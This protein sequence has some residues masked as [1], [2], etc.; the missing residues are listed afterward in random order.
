MEK[1]KTG[2]L[3]LT[4]INRT[5]IPED[6][7]CPV[8]LVKADTLPQGWERSV[9]VCWEKGI[10]IKT[11]YDRP[12]DPPS[13]DCTMIIEVNNPFKEPRIHR[14]MPAGLED[15]ET[16]RQEVLYGIHDDWI[17]PEEGKWEYTYH[18]RIFNYTL[19][20]ESE[21]V[22]QIDFVVEKLA[23]TPFS[24]RAQAVTWKCWMDP[25]FDDPPCLQRLW[26]RIIDNHL[27]LNVHLRSNDAF[28]AA[29]MNMFAFTELQ[30]L[31]AEKIS[32]KTNKKIKPGKYIHIADS[33]HI[34][35]SYFKEFKN[36]LETVKKRSFEERTWTTSFAQPFFEEAARR[37]RKEN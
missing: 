36:F 30:K 26:F 35:G 33:Y 23:R 17:K 20:G 9:V 16:Y 21:P 22:N 25:K 3:I 29:F 1:K 19:P 14:A 28:K 24:R 8:F 18:E 11:E 7:G 32:K 5:M 15:L 4:K 2:N 34:Y 27:Q 10:S 6:N 37:L 12:G 13:R 31:V